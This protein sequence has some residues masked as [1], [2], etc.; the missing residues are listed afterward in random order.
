MDALI[1]IEPYN[2]AWPA[3]FLAE[4][5]LLVRVLERW[6]VGRVEHFVDLPA[7]SDN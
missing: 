1:H 2:P 5:D 6:L 3:A 4:R 7:L